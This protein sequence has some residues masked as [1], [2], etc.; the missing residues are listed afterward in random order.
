MESKGLSTGRK[1]Q[2]SGKDMGKQWEAEGL[3][4]DA[5]RQQS[6]AGGWSSQLQTTSPRHTVS[7]PIPPEAQ[8]LPSS[9]PAPSTYPPQAPP[10]PCLNS[11]QA[12]RATV[13]TSKSS[14]VTGSSPLCTR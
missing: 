3:Q 6:E 5:R 9:N 1:W 4:W 10:K 8:P 11:Q 14:R 12:P 13:A 7:M 2:G